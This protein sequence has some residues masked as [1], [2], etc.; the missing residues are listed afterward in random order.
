MLEGREIVVNPTVRTAQSA[1]LLNLL[2]AGLGIIL[3]QRGRLVL[4]G[5]TIAIGRGAVAFLGDEGAGKS[6]FT[7]ALY[8]L[9]QGLVADDV[10]GIEIAPEGPTV[11]PG[12]P[13][14]KI[15]PDAA[16]AL[17]FDVAQLPR[18]HSKVEKRA[19]RA[20]RN[21]ARGPLPLRHIYTLA[22]GAIPE[23]EPMGPQEALPELIRHSYCHRL[24][25]ETGDRR[26]FLQCTQ[27]AKSVKISRLRIPRSLA[28]LPEAARL[29]ISHQ[30]AVAKD[31]RSFAL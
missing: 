13:Q 11:Y 4:H 28:V 23:I 19:L 2:G 24:L 15:W 14:I 30:N 10:T 6:T 8:Q 17:G 21:F 22:E 16:E 26:H 12:Y 3:H 18:L 5:S 9:G 27:V 20:T 7:A 31:A 29:V 1:L 25:S